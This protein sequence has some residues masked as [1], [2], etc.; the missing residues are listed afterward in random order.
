LQVKEITVPY[1]Q[2]QHEF[3]LFCLSDIHSGTI[4]CV[5]DA[6]KNKVREIKESPD[7]MWIGLGDYCEFITPSDKRFDPDSRAIADWVH[8]DNVAE[9]ET[10]WIVKLLEPVKSKCVGMLYGNHENAIRTHSHVNVAQNICDRLGVDNLGYS[11][12]VNFKFKRH[13]SSETHVYTGAFTHGSSGAITEGA[14]MMAL[15]RFMKAF[16]ADMY[17]YAHVHDYIP[18]SLSRMVVSN[19]EIKSRSSIGATTGSWFRTYTQGNVSSYGEM[20][21]YP[22]CEIGAACFTIDPTTGIIDVNFSR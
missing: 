18:K 2:A 9:D 20:K 4:H 10:K 11:A 5:E 22:A 19:G 12:F 8:Q 14:K 17:G 21:V 13:N 7:A 15:M 1:R 3:K 16:E 6:I